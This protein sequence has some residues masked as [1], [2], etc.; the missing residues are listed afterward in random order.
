VILILK[1]LSASCARFLNSFSSMK[2]SLLASADLKALPLL[3]DAKSPP[4]RRTARRNSALLILPSPF[5]SNAVVN[6]RLNCSTVITRFPSLD[7]LRSMKAMVC[8]VMYILLSPFKLAFGIYSV[9][10]HNAYPSVKIIIMILLP[11]IIINRCFCSLF[12]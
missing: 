1:C 7:T 8:Y 4:V 12:N 3:H 5:A 11:L 2:P 6:H 10:V 9:N